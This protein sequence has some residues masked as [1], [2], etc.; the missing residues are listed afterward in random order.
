MR[1]NCGG[2]EVEC[3]FC[4]EIDHHYLLCEKDQEG[5]D[6]DQGVVKVTDLN[7]VTKEPE[8]TGFE[9]LGEIV[10]PKKGSHPFK[11]FCMC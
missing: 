11:W 6:D 3:R 9:A 4:K 8:D 10:P 5:T 1:A 2:R 7:P